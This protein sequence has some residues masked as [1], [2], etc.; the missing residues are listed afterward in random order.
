VVRRHDRGESDFIAVNSLADGTLSLVAPKR[1][2]LSHDAGKSWSEVS[3]PQYVTGLYN[4]TAVPD[5]S[6]GCHEGRRVA[7]D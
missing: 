4:L 3:Y 7:L 1:A 5:G 6:C 2:F